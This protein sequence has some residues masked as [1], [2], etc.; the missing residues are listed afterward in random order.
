MIKLEKDINDNYN[1]KFDL[2]YE[3]NVLDKLITNLNNLNNLKRK[4]Y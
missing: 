4:Y 2:D 1:Y 3:T